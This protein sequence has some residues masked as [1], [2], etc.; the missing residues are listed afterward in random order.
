MNKDTSEDDRK[1]ITPKSSH[2][3]AL[4][5]NA[6]DS[7]GFRYSKYQDSFTEKELEVSDATLRQHKLSSIDRFFMQTNLMIWKNYLIFLRNIKM[8][9]FQLLTPIFICVLL[10]LMQFILDE[11]STGYINK[12]P[13]LI[14]LENIAQCKFP[15]DCIT[16]GYG[17]VV[18]FIINIFFFLEQPN[19]S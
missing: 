3:L 9:I 6:N 10:I 7:I 18:S 8:T 17:I 4:K 1:E 2:I 12:D 15:D 5:M 16:I 13:E 14:P 11:F 19:K